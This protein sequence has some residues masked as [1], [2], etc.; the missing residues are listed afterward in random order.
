VGALYIAASGCRAS[1]QQ[2][3]GEKAGMITAAARPGDAVIADLR[4]FIASSTMPMEED[5]REMLE[6]RHHD[7]ARQA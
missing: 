7:H 5:R 2:R 4:A 1:Q 6:H 3:L